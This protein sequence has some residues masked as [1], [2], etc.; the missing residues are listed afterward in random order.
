MTPRDH[1]LR[2]DLAAA[3]Y[4][5][6]LE[7]NDFET[8]AALWRQAGMDP[9]LGTVLCEL[10]AGLMEEQSEQQAAATTLALTAAVRDYLPSAEVLSPTADP[11]TVAD[12]AEVLF[13]RPPGRLSPEAHALNNRLRSAAEPLPEH[14][15]LSKLVAWAEAR[16]GKAPLEYWTAFREAALELDL[17]RASEAELQ[18]A[19]RRARSNLEGKP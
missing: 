18:M 9:A 10:H 8:M 13:H 11:L 5:E 6:A 19:A 3:R 2:L 12:V 4:L 7:R 17:R 15:G 16:F 14:L 1:R